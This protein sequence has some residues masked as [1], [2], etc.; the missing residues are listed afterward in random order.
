MSSLSNT[1]RYR[2]YNSQDSPDRLSRRR[3][4]NGIDEPV[5][6]QDDH[7]QLVRMTRLLV[8][9]VDE[10][11]A[12][13]IPSLLPTLCYSSFGVRV[14]ILR[15][16]IGQFPNRCFAQTSRSTAINPRGRRG[17]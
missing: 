6:L 13:A 2:A 17:R 12:F 3:A 14:G 11:S 10:V 15:L 1:F 5:G 9:R 4:P 16:T 8:V 7:I